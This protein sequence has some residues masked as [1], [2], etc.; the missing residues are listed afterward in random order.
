MSFIKAKEYA[1]LVTVRWL[2]ACCATRPVTASSAWQISIWNPRLNAHPVATK[3]HNAVRSTFL[4]APPVPTIL[5][6][7]LA[8][9]AGLST[10]NRLALPAPKTGPNANSVIMLHA[11]LVYRDTFSSIIPAYSAIILFRIA[12]YVPTQ[13]F[14]SCVKSLS[15]LGMEDVLIVQ[16]GRWTESILSILLI[17]H[18]VNLALWLIFNAPIAAQTGYAWDAERCITC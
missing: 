8:K 9:S 4:I 11:L 18:N 6:V 3:F 7:L 1:S 15:F 12:T 10:T 2:T 16:L 17:F 5:L 14:A 13:R